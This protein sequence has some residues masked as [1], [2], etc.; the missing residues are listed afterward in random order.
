MRTPLSP[1]A[2]LSGL[3]TLPLWRLEDAQLTRTIT[4]PTFMEAIAFVNSAA[5]LAE[6]ADHHPDFDIRYNRVRLSL[7]T[8][9]A[10]GITSR[11]FLLAARI[12]A[13]V[14]E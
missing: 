3:A 1:D 8:H 2:V 7:T 11:D 4:F 9:D 10:G 6:Q 5:S 14:T 13:L 12:D